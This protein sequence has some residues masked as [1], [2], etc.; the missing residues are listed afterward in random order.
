MSS[1]SLSVDDIDRESGADG[2]NAVGD[3]GLNADIPNG[4]VLAFCGLNDVAPNGSTAKN[5]H[6]STMKILL[7]L[8]VNKPAISRQSVLLFEETGVPRENH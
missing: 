6:N 5:K 7:S 4:S 1:N 8:N 2:L 3:D